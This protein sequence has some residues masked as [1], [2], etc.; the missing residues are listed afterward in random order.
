M[1][2]NK[3]SDCQNEIALYKAALQNYQLELEMAIAEKEF[4]NVRRRR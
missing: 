4:Q 3:D 1:T 2:G